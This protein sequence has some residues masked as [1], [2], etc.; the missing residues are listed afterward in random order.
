MLFILINKVFK[1]IPQ[2]KAWK[3]VLQCLINDIEVSIS[4]FS[5]VCGSPA[6]FPHCLYLLLLVL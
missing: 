1:H 2:T 5:Q 3:K 4:V 6:V